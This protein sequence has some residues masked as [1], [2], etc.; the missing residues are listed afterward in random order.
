MMAI[1]KDWM[2]EA[3]REIRAGCMVSLNKQMALDAEARFV[4]IIAK[5]CPFT[6]ETAEA[7]NET[8]NAPMGL[9]PGRG[10]DE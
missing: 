3:A 6:P 10:Y 1:V 4:Q 7:Q 2:T 5:H 8:M 9:D